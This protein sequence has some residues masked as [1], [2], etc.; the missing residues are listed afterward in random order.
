MRLGGV[1]RGF[2]EGFA[3]WETRSKLAFGLAAILMIVVLII[4]SRLP[5]EQRS[6]VV[7]GII[8]LLVAMQAIFL[9]ANRNM[10]TPFTQAQRLILTGRYTEAITLLENPA[11]GALDA[12]S[13][14]L[15]GS[16]YRME[17]RVDESLQTLT[18]AIQMSPK[19]HFPLYSFGRT[20]MASGRYAEAED[21]FRRAVEYGAPPFARVD[22]AEAAYRSG[23]A[24]AFDEP[25]AGEPHVALMSSYLK[26]RMGQGEQPEIALITD[27]IPYWNKT[28]A[29]FMH[30]PYGADLQRDI[31]AL[32]TLSRHS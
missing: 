26:W 32:Y 24:L 10:V 23:R 18:K 5:E 25:A 27:G 31:D 28:A 22:L 16:A 20:L 9:H 15:L 11:D 6:A 12:Q 13:L 2:T 4:G 8:G 7:I 29:R 19:H 1:A 21:A 17:G 14:T 30:T 3:N